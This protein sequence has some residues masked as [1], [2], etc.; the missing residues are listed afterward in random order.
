MHLELRY[1]NEAGK[2]VAYLYSRLDGE[3]DG[4]DISM[5][6]ATSIWTSAL[7]AAEQTRAF[8]TL[9]Y[10]FMKVALQSLCEHGEQIPLTRSEVHTILLV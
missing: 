8:I 6:A 10:E 3:L 5:G 9:V 4:L 2:I 1:N 7:R